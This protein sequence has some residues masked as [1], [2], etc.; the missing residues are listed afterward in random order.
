MIAFS[1]PFM[2]TAALLILG[3]SE[4]VNGQPPSEGVSV[5]DEICT[6]GYVMDEFCIV[7]LP[8]LSS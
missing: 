4:T 7:R 1:R 8:L 2:A 3:I 6:Y 5:G